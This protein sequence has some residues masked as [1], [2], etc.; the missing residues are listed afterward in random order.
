MRILIWGNASWCLGVIYRHV[1]KGI[2]AEFQN[3]DLPVSREFLGKF[4]YIFTE[5]GLGTNFLIKNY[6]IPRSKIYAVGHAEEDL[7]RM[8]RFDGNDSIKYYAGY[9]V[10][11]DTLASG[12][13]AMGITRIP[14][15]LR[16]GVDCDFFYSPIP[17]ELKVVGYAASLWRPSEHGVEIKRGELVRLA[18]QQAGLEFKA[19]VTETRGEGDYRPKNPIPTEQMPDFYRS[20]D[21]IVTSSVMEGGSV[22]TLE[23]AAAGRLNISTP[24]GHAA[25][26]AYE[27]LCIL[28]PLDAEAFVRFTRD[29]LIYYKKHTEEF[30]DKCSSIQLAART[31]RDWSVV[32]E[33]WKDF[34]SMR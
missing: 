12:S 9:A 2:G 20:T 21:C 19:A 24:Q 28:G 33:D 4:D 26:L 31:N 22:V 1:S 11:S 6:G 34:V 32:L 14:K 18:A 3:W 30:R 8:L 10:V 17:Q 29:T 5:A 7:T 13:L 27:G 25:R 16:L 15:V 23:A